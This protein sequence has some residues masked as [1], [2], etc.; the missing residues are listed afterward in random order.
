MKKLRILSG[1]ILL[2]SVLNMGCAGFESQSVQS[3]LSDVN[4]GKSQITT[5]PYCEVD[6]A[7]YELDLKLLSFEIK[8]KF[9]VGF[10]YNL[11][12]GFLRAFGISVKTERGEMLMSGHLREALRPLESVVDALGQ[13]NSKGV[14]FNFSLDLV[15]LGADF[16]Y[17]YQTPLHKLTEKTIKSNLSNLRTELNAVETPWATRIV[18]S[19]ERIQQ[20]IIPAGSVAGIRIGDEFAIYNVEN[21]WQGEPCESDLLFRR[22]VTLTPAA[23]AVVTQLEK[24]AALLTISQMRSD[25]PLEDGAAVEIF[26]LPLKKNEKQRGLARSVRLSRLESEPISVQ[27]GKTVDLTSY[28]KE[29]SA[30]LLNQYGWYPRN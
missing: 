24:Q 15:Q 20:Y 12:S 16:G 13:G 27:N 19:F 4:S 30:A 2:N 9:N 26:N 21:V 3:V 18:H 17:Y 11:I 23:I 14:D 1:I 6:L 22:K 7:D 8:D 25:L 5:K 29:Q 28:L 10:G